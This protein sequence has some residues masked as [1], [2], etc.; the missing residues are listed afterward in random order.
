[1][2]VARP[3]CSRPRQLR[4][5]NG[6]S[7]CSILFHLLAPAEGGRRGS[8]CRVPATASASRPS[9]AG[10]E[11]RSSRRDRRPRD[12][13]CLGDS[14]D[15]AP[16]E[17]AALRRRRQAAPLPVGMQRQR[18]ATLANAVDS[19]CRSASCQAKFA[20]RGCF[21]PREFPRK[22][23]PFRYAR[24]V[25]TAPPCPGAAACRRFG[26]A[27]AFA[28]Q[29]QPPR[30]GS[31]FGFCPKSHTGFKF[32][33]KHAERQAT[34][35]RTVAESGPVRLSPAGLGGSADFRPDGLSPC[36]K[37]KTSRFQP[38][39]HRPEQACGRSLKSPALVTAFDLNQCRLTF[40][41]LDWRTCGGQTGKRGSFDPPS[42]GT[43]CA[44]PGFDNCKI[45]GNPA[46]HG[47][48]GS[49]DPTRP[50]STS[51][52][53]RQLVI[54]GARRRRRT[55]AGAPTIIRPLQG[56][57]AGSPASRPFR[58]ECTCSAML[59]IFDDVS[60]SSC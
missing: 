13:G 45:I 19:L 16:A 44:F 55:L 39:G 29:R 33:C 27:V 41:R 30:L 20:R 24:F 53:R 11:R 4:L 26:S 58:P 54:A 2:T 47:R 18:L 15:A 28:E 52:R 14:A 46:C 23:V 38:D 32:R 25:P 40:G 36:A 50:P 57:P 7:R 9:T 43:P 8:R 10:P 5:E 34:L 56:R 1:M 22:S 48:P 35:G 12:A 3:T 6:N 37:A 51:I 60:V 59:Q 49:F 31:H 21:A 42:M 17:T